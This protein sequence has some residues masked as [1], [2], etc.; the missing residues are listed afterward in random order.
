MTPSLQPLTA[1]VW[2]RSLSVVRKPTSPPVGP[3]REGALFAEPRNV[4]TKN[5]AIL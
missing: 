4:R 2:G 5:E 1:P 3:E